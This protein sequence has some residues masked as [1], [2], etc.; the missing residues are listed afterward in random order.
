MKKK[1]QKTKKKKQKEKKEKRREKKTTKNTRRRTKEEV[2][3]DNLKAKQGM[4]YERLIPFNGRR[5]Y[6]CREEFHWWQYWKKGE[7]NKEILRKKLP[8]YAEKFTNWDSKKENSYAEV[9]NV[10]EGVDIDDGKKRSDE[11][12]KQMRKERLQQRRMTIREQLNQPI[13]MEEYEKG[14]YELIRERI[15]AERDTMM[16]EAEERGDFDVK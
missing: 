6:K 2:E 14:E 5:R 12:M 13:E 4:E 16:K 15:I 11:Q 1:K 10:V 9:E 7:K 8:E 3:S